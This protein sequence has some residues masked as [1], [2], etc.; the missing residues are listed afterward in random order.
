MKIHSV[1]PKSNLLQKV[2]FITEREPMETNY[3]V[4]MLDEVEVQQVINCGETVKSN[5]SKFL[6]DAMVKFKKQQLKQAF[7]K[8]STH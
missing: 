2:K 4:E 5:I 8:Q 7:G 6:Q 1:N 3:D